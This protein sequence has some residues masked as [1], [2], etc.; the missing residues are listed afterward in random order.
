MRKLEAL[1]ILA[2]LFFLSSCGVFNSN[3]SETYKADQQIKKMERH[4]K[5]SLAFFVAGH[6]YGSPGQNP[7]GL[8]SVFR[9]FLK[10]QTG[11]V[12]AWDFGFLTGD[13]VVD[14]K[15]Q[16][17][18]EMVERDL[19]RHFGKPAFFV[20]GN[21]DVNV[22]VESR[23]TFEKRY[24]KTYYSFQLGDAVFIVL[25]ANLEKPTNIF[26]TLSF[27][28]QEYNSFSLSDLFILLFILLSL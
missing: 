21:H 7:D 1:F 12:E 14:G 4:S 16:E 20:A 11:I 25:D 13:I 5:E 2:S 27:L 6:V 23:Q 28:K 10:K 19:N 9:S 8:Y 3:D 18:W 17:Q 15:Q 26:L 22:G 24:G